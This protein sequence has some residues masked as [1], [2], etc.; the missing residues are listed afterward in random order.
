MQNGDGPRL[1]LLDQQLSSGLTSESIPMLEKALPALPSAN[2][3]LPSL[4]FDRDSITAVAVSNASKAL[5]MTM[6]LTAKSSAE[7]EAASLSNPG[8]DDRGRN[9]QVVDD[10]VADV[11]SLAEE[12]EL[13]SKDVNPTQKLNPLKELAEKAKSF[14]LS[15]RP[16]SIYSE[17]NIAACRPPESGEMILDALHEDMSGH[18]D[19]VGSNSSMQTWSFDQSQTSQSSYSSAIPRSTLPGNYSEPTSPGSLGIR[20]RSGHEDQA[21]R[22]GATPVIDPS[23][24]C[25]GDPVTDEDLNLQ[26]TAK[27]S[28]TMNPKTAS[29]CAFN[30]RHSDSSVIVRLSCTDR[31]DATLSDVPFASSTLSPNPTPSSSRSQSIDHTLSQSHSRTIHHCFQM[32][33]RPIPHLLHPDVEGPTEEPAAPYTLTFTTPQYTFLSSSSQSPHWSSSLLYIFTSPSDRRLVCSRL[34]GKRLLLIA[35]CNKI[36]YAGQELAHMCAI[37]L[38]RDDE[39]AGISSVTFFPNLKKGPPRDVELVVSGLCERGK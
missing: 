24:Q 11:V 8:E 15:V 33:S 1:G 22:L 29:D 17:S 38:W 34:F 5:S 28:L 39:G 25:G 18:L 23:V 31:Q 9:V 6:T 2:T 14:Q 32:H 21:I 27:V 19:T 36:V 7:S 35:G 10:F 37:A 3:V 12:T 30:I 4:E 13:Y 16:A 20:C 26:G